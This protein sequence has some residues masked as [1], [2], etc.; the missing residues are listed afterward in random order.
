MDLKNTSVIVIHDPM[1]NVHAPADC[2][3][4]TTTDGVGVSAVVDGQ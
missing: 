4:I 3:R 1:Q 2:S